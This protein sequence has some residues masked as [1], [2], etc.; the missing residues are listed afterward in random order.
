MNRASSFS[1]AYCFFGFCLPTVIVFYIA[2]N[3]EKHFFQISDEILFPGWITVLILCM[4]L[5]SKADE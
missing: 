4:F 1:L 2:E 3:F 5:L